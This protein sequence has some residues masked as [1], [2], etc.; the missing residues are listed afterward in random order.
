MFTNDAESSASLYTSNKSNLRDKVLGEI[1]KDSCIALPGNGRQSRHL[2]SKAMCPNL[3]GSGAEFYSSGASQLAQW[4]RSHLPVQETLFTAVVS[5]WAF[6]QDEGMSW[7]CPPF[8]SS[9][10]VGLLIWK[11][12][13]GPR[14]QPELVSWLLLPWLTTVR[15]CPLELRE[16]H[17]VWSFAY[18]KWGPKKASMP[19]SPTGS[20]SVSL[21][22][23]T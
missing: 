6:W 13:S 16:G 9:Q 22:T 17:G 2:S 15:I 21:I 1:E 19:G 3:G 10:V 18:R 7:A 14:N 23:R 4:R 12:F 11:S 8:I 20:R 5:G